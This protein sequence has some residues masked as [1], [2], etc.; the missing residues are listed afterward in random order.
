MGYFEQL[1]ASSN[2][3]LVNMLYNRVVSDLADS[4]GEKRIPYIGWFWRDADFVHKQITIGYIPSESYIGVMENNK[5]DYP[6]R[7]MTVAEVDKFIELIDTVI[8]VGSA[9][10]LASDLT[11]AKDAALKELH[12]W[13]QT[14]QVPIR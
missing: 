10:G 8:R 7:L 4:N 5:W 13:M 14:L 9:G 2:A 3:E 1:Q 6:E 11:A 12:D